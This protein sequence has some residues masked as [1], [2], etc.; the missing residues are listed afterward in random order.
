MRQKLRGQP[1]YSKWSS[2]GTYSYST[3]KTGFNE[4]IYN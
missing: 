1:L 2:A 3:L 4:F